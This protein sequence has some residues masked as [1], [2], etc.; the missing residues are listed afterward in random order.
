MSAGQPPD[1]AD[2]V[3]QAPQVLREEL[4]IL[5]LMTGACGVEPLLRQVDASEER[6][7]GHRRRIDLNRGHQQGLG[8]IDPA[9]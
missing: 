3:I 5:Q 1:A 9:G 7:G 2:L 4:E 6:I 8:A